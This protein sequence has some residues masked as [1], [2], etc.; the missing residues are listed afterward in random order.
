MLVLQK[1]L[2]PSQ[3][4]IEVVLIWNERIVDSYHFSRAGIVPINFAHINEIA[5]PSDLKDD[6]ILVM[7]LGFEVT[8][9]IKFV[10][11]ESEPFAAPLFDLNQE[12]RERIIATF[13]L[14]AILALYL[15]VFPYEEVGRPIDRPAEAQRKVTFLYTKPAE[16]FPE[17]QKN[18]STP[19]PNKIKRS[20]GLLDSLDEIGRSIE[21]VSRTSNQV[22]ALGTGASGAA[23]KN[24]SKGL[25]GAGMKSSGPG[26]AGENTVGLPDGIRNG[27][28]Y[29]S[30]G[31]GLGTKTGVNLKIGGQG[32]FFQGSIDKEGIR[33]VVRD[34]QQEV[35][36]CYER[37]LNQSPGLS[38]KIVME[39]EI[40]GHG[41]VGR[42]K[43]QSSSVGNRGVADCMSKALKGW[44]FPEPPTDQIAVVAFPFVFLPLE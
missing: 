44:I 43:V 29:G 12:E 10:E 26:G 20:S 38:G 15:F 31:P 13:A 33:R 7:D 27:K 34:H 37:A 22:R 35:Q 11:K 1:T 9:Q 41:R 21:K 28:I 39:W 32:E 30:T 19:L 24:D 4:L 16:A 3:R 6:E 8:A 17:L 14:S 2:G 23:T 40:L 25:D 42:V 36:A 5:I 18:I